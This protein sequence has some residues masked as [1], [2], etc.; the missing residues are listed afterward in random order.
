VRAPVAAAQAAP[1]LSINDVSVTEGNPGAPLHSAVFTI[2][3]KAAQPASISFQL[4][5]ADGSARQPGDYA[6]RIGTSTI[7][8]GQLSTT[9]S[10]PIVADTTSE[11][12]E[13]FSV[14][15][16]NSIATIARSRGSA[17]IVNDDPIPALSISNATVTE[18]N[19]G[20]VNA[21]LLVALSNPASQT[22]S[23]TV[24]T[25]HG[26]A[27]A[28]PDYTALGQRSSRLPPASSACR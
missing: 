28:G 22:V 23:V 19:S 21:S 24:A 9:I 16:S 20:A 18:G 11:P 2:S 8:A 4:K 12:D 15:L 10:L 6:S 5:T 13:T 26:T 7:P 17:T 27:K 25:A 3:L 14:D 1:T